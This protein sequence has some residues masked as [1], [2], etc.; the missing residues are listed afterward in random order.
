[1]LAT[2]LICGLSQAGIVNVLAPTIGPPEPGF[3]G[4][5]FAGVDL[6][7]GNEDTTALNGAAGFLFTDDSVEHQLMLKSSAQYATAFGAVTAQKAMAHLRYRWAFHAPWIAFTFVQVDHNAFRD[8][9]ARN[10]LGL[11]IERR[12]WRAD[13]TEASVGLAGMAEYEVRI[14]DADDTLPVPR[15]SAFFLLAVK[16]EDNLQLG[17]T[18]FYQ[19]HLLDPINDWRFLEEL[20]LSVAIGEHLGWANT[21][22]VEIDQLPAANIES[23]D[24]AASSGLT[25]GW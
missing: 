8:L 17:S 24:L 9:Q 25:Y 19:P 14:D 12:L 13:W 1:M 23:F 18:T 5:L 3:T 15:A 11:G 7:R 22:H 2:L 21:L 4:D 10:L 6:A 20:T 16:L